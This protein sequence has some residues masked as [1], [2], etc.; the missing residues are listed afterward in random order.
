MGATHVPRPKSL[1]TGRWLVGLGSS[2]S[3]LRRSA[4]PSSAWRTLDSESCHC[5]SE[6]AEQA[7]GA[8]RCSGRLR[9]CC[10]RASAGRGMEVSNTGCCGWHRTARGFYSRGCRDRRVRAA[11][12]RAAY[13]SFESFFLGEGLREELGDH[14]GSFTRV[15][16]V[17]SGGSTVS[18]ARV[19]VQT[20]LPRESCSTLPLGPFCWRLKSG[21]RIFTVST[22]APRTS[23]QGIRCS[24]L[25][26]GR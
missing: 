18:V 24:S 5:G 6:A 8:R 23:A 17:L 20:A 14:G 10:R 2:S 4:W 15:I 1:A 3:R 19:L 13:L 7:A 9:Y 22:I 21:R 11:G 16:P 26:H 25:K 12:A